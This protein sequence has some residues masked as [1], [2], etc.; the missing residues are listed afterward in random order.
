[1]P[2]EDRIHDGVGCFSLKRSGTAV[3]E[4]RFEIIM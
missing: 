3:A 2:I 4:N 1:M